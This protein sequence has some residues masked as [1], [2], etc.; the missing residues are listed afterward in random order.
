MNTN[1]HRCVVTSPGTGPG[2]GRTGALLLSRQVTAGSE[3]ATPY[4]HFGLLRT[5]EDTFGLAH[6]GYAGAS[7][8]QSFG[9]GRTG[10]K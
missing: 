7:A 1:D 5:I 9:P 6:L 4:N 3:N 10:T 2:G 8:V